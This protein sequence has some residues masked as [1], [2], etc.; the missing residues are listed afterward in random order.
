MILIWLTDIDFENWSKTSK[1]GPIGCRKLE[2][3]YEDNPIEL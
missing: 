2:L 1:F 3:P